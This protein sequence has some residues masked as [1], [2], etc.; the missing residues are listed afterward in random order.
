MRGEGLS[1]WVVVVNATIGLPFV[2]FICDCS[3]VFC[4]GCCVWM[5]CSYLRYMRVHFF[6]GSG[7]V[8]GE[9]ILI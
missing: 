7:V 9:M 1:F 2:G 6:L 8:V 5:G 3:D 4:Y